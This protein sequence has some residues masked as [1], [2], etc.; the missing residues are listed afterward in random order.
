MRGMFCKLKGK[1]VGFKASKTAIT[2]LK[3]SSRIIHK[4]YS[5]Y[6]ALIPRKFKF[7][8]VKASEVANSEELI[9]PSEKFVMPELKDVFGIAH[10][11]FSSYEVVMPAFYVRKFNNA[12]CYTNREEVFSEE[13]EVILEYTSQKENPF[14]GRCK[15]RLPVN[16]S[17]KINACVAHLSLYGLENNY[18]HFLV[19]CLGRLYLIEKSSFKPDYYIIS[20]HLPFQAE[21]LQILKI[22]PNRIIPTNEAKLIQAK[23]L[24]VASFVNNWKHINYRGYIHCQ[25]QWLPKWIGDFYRSK[26][27]LNDNIIE[28]RKRIYISRSQ[29]KYRKIENENEVIK[30]FVNL[31][32]EV[33]SLETMSVRDQ[34]VLFSQ[35]EI[36]AGIHGAGFINMSFAPPGTKIF[37]IFTEH[38][39]D[40]GHRL[41]AKVLCNQYYYMVGTTSKVENIHPQQE[42]VYIDCKN[43]KQVIADILQKAA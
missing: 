30:V 10:K 5:S 6:E 43:L 27:N 42:D 9:F 31:G 8:G 40:A 29:A 41:Q 35:A 17:V 36:I 11:N 12:Y 39:H 1:L 34:I 2:V 4:C 28:C 15:R 13:Q 38:Y 7:A 20:N 25:K 37:E 33:Y 21:L 19:E 26:I 22:D 3:A 16:Q 32:F 24:I 23:E 14:L 18:Y